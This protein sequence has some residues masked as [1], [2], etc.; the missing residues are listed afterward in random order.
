[1][2]DILLS[3]SNPAMTITPQGPTSFCAGGSVMLTASVANQYSWSN[4]STTQSITVNTSGNY[5][6][7]GTSANGCTT[8]SAPVTVNASACATTVNI[9]VFIDALYNG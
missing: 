5:T 4:G 1:I 7:T 3:G 6:V 2:D 8:T 9:K